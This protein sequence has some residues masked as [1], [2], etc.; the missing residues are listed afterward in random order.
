MK[1]RALVGY[2]G[3]SLTGHV[4]GLQASAEYQVTSNLLATQVDARST[5]R[6][7]N[8][9]VCISQ[10]KDSDDLVIV[11]FCNNLLPFQITVDGYYA[12]EKSDIM[13]DL[14]NAHVVPLMSDYAEKLSK[15]NRE[16]DSKAVIKKLIKEIIAKHQELTGNKRELLDQSSFTMAVSIAYQNASHHLRC[17]GFGIGDIGLVLKRVNGELVQLAANNRSGSRGF[18]LSKQGFDRLNYE[19]FSIDQ[20]IARNSIFDVSV[21]PSDELVSYTSVMDAL[22]IETEIENIPQFIDGKIKETSVS[23]THLNPALFPANQSLF[24]RLTTLNAKALTDA[25]ADAVATKED[26]QFGDDCVMSSVRI[27]TEAERLTLLRKRC[28][29]EENLLKR[30]QDKG[31]KY[32]LASELIEKYNAFRNE[33]SQSSLDETTQVTI[34]EKAL[35][36][37]TAA[38]QMRLFPTTENFQKALKMIEENVSAAIGIVNAA[39]IDKKQQM[40]NV[41]KSLMKFGAALIVFGMVLTA[42]SLAL[43]LTGILAAPA[44][45]GMII[46]GSLIGVGAATSLAGFTLFKCKSKANQDA[47]QPEIKQPLLV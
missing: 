7:Y 22:T 14:I 9:G 2:P 39:P 19:R 28:E 26:V 29:D 16:A 37:L 17:A 25:C 6:Q 42:V 47:P 31:V 24:E 44:T 30:L 8:D 45:I 23:R 20:L 15:C 4:Q 43:S 12:C 38:N 32:D 34:L 3:V 11:G 36:M 18:S 46:G 1:G 41:A 21:K 40:E 27:P 33:L 10:A 35:P 13:F 5:F